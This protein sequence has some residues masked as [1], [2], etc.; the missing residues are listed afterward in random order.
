MADLHIYNS[1]TR[2]KEPFVPLVPG[3]VTIYL[4]GL[5]VYDDWH[6]GHALQAI[7]FDTFRRY[8][9]SRGLAVV[10][11]NNFTDVDDKII[12]R[13]A[14]EGV[15]HG[16]IADRYVKSYLED[17][18]TLNI[19]PADHQP[20]ATEHIPQMIEMIGRLIDRG[21]AYA[22]CGNVLFDVTTWPGYGQLSGQ[23][24]DAN[25]AADD[26]A[27]P[28]GSRRHP[29]DFTLWKA[30]KPSEPSWESPWGPGRPG[31]HIECSAMAAQYL[32]TPFDIHGGGLDL[33]FPHHENERAQSEAAIGK[34]FARYWMHNGLLKVRGGDKM[35]K[36]LGNTLG[37]RRLLERYSANTLR[38]FVLSSHYRSPGEFD[39]KLLD[40]SAKAL[41]RLANLVERVQAYQ[42]R[43]GPAAG[44]AEAAA[45][46]LEAAGRAR[47]RFDE[48]LADDFNTAG[49]MGALFELAGDANRTLQEWE[50]EP[51]S[52]A[53]AS[54]LSAVGS[55]I[56]QSM[57]LLGFFPLATEA[58]RPTLAGP[59]VELLIE[60][61]AEA[62]KRKDFA[63]SD[64]IRK[65]LAELGVELKDGAEGTR[66][67]IKAKEGEG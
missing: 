24:P 34:P 41:D 22:S 38:H 66:Y 52:T 10:F 28:G 14:R 39:F 17:L 18:P 53:R 59:L 47:R 56:G 31:W 23:D 60:V 25:R 4:C 29:A 15:S 26:P 7:L 1:L 48:C 55:A 6:L 54:A 45:P 33:V 43:P 67:T 30:A 12:N 13:A 51:T 16:T 44:A 21:H 57:E 63:Q 37:V 36:S 19:L 42:H 8:L 5:T 64:R 3:R 46:L 35:S 49:A 11:V 50:K 32:G 40:D 65:R 2:K 20:R 27:L 9:K 62:R 61:R 58:A